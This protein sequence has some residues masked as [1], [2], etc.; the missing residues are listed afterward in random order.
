[1]ASA[2]TVVLRTIST[3][4]STSASSAASSAV[5]SCGFSMHSKPRW[6]SLVTARGWHESANRILDGQILRRIACAAA[7]GIACAAAGGIACDAAGGIACAAAGGIACAAAGG[8]GCAAA[9]VG[10][11][12]AMLR[13]PMP[14]SPMMA[15]CRGRWKAH[16][17]PIRTGDAGGRA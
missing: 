11:G 15:L 13:C 7:G 12:E 1:M 16:L 6:R 5:P 8:I 2:L 3:S 4:M 9:G 10:G 17:T 14:T